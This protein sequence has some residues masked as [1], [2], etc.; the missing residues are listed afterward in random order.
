ML[1]LVADVEM[2][3]TAFAVVRRL[4]DENGG[5]SRADLFN[6]F[7]WGGERVRLDGHVEGIWKPKAMSG[8]L[9]IKTAWPRQRRERPSIYADQRQVLREHFEASDVLDYNFERGGPEMRRNQWLLDAKIRRIPILYLMAASP[10]SYQAFLPSYIVEW[11]DVRNTAKVAFG[12]DAPPE[13]ERERR[14]GIAIARRQFERAG[15]R[16]EV[17]SAYRERCAISRVAGRSHVSVAELAPAFGPAAALPAGASAGLALSKLHRSAF[18]A[19]LL[20]IDADGRVHVSPRAAEHRAGVK[21]LGSQP[22][23]PMVDALLAADGARIAEPDRPELRPDRD[24]LDLRFQHFRQ[25]N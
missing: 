19:D 10:G 25:A 16:E 4:Q 13:T 18:D 7:R 15:F 2:R 24:L 6:G 8:L 11:D 20:G 12:F 22:D 14:I 17:L 3:A 23:A 1:D 21:L 9:S 5:L